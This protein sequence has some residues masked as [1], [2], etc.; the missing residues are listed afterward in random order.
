MELVKY[1]VLPKYLE[2]IENGIKTIELRKF[3]E[4]TLKILQELKDNE[5]SKMILTN[6]DDDRHYIEV[7]I[8]KVVLLPKRY[9]FETTMEDY[10]CRT[11][12]KKRCNWTFASEFMGWVY[13]QDSKLDVDFIQ[14]AE[15]YYKNEDYI[16]IYVLEA[17][18]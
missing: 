13:D 1:K 14:W 17:L 16:V 7:D 4:K 10:Y 12:I 2:K 3:D 11:S 8:T 18:E 5:I 9:N 6:I 15:D